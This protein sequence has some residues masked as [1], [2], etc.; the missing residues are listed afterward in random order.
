MTRIFLLLASLAAAGC[1]GEQARTAAGPPAGGRGEPVTTGGLSAPQ[2]YSQ[3]PLPTNHRIST[4][5]ELQAVQHWRVVAASVAIATRRL[6]EQDPAGLAR[7]YRVEPAV[8]WTPFAEAFHALLVT[9]LVKAGIAITPDAAGAVAIRYEIQLLEFG[10]DRKTGYWV[11]GTGSLPPELGISDSSEL[12]SGGVPRYELLV[13]TS[14]LRDGAYWVRRSDIFY[15]RDED[16]PLYRTASQDRQ[17]QR[18]IDILRAYEA[19]RLEAEGWPSYA[20]P[21]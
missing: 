5:R 10:P 14:I 12:S 21:R 1:A 9:E 18:L 20:I 8:P 3:V 16:A 6:I 4:Q 7:R 15:V 13:T 19:K 2:H 11:Y 17:Q